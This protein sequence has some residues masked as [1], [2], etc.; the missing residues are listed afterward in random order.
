[1]QDCNNIQYD[2]ELN[3]RMNKRYFPTG[4]LRPVFDI[5]PVSTKYG[6]FPLFDEKKRQKQT[7]LIM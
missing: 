1:M 3:E 6:H 4:A 7:F 2:N 5:R